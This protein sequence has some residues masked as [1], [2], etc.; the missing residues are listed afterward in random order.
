MNSPNAMV[1]F[2]DSLSLT[3]PATIPVTA[4]G[5]R[6][7]CVD[8]WTSVKGSETVDEL[9]ISGGSVERA[10]AEGL[11]ATTIPWSKGAR[12]PNCSWNAGMVE[13]APIEPVSAPNSAPP[14]R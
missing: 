5:T 6:M 13:I 12:T 3:A 14:A 8:P 9:Y 4:E 2:L 11:T 7:I 1:R 10:S